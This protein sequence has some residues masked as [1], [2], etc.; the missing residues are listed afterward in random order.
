MKIDFIKETKVNGDAFYFTQV[1]NKFVD[2]SLSYDR[3][4]T[5]KIYDNIVSHCGK[6]DFTEV[7][8]S[9]EIEEAK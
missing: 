3:N 5:K 1:D 7:L 2:K 9:V 8:E 4:K 6:I